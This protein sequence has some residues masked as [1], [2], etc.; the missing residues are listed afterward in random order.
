MKR[1]I[2]EV[3]ERVEAGTATEQELE[4]ARLWILQLKQGN[5]HHFT[6]EQLV[7]VSDQMWAAISKHQI[8]NPATQ[9]RTTTIKLW[10]RVA[11]IA[12]AVTALAFGVYFFKY[13]DSDKLNQNQDAVAYQNDIAPGRQGATLTLANGKTIKLTDATNGKLAEQSGVSITKTA[14]GKLIYEIKDKGVE[15]NN[16]NT[17]TTA[18]GETYD[19]RLP[20]GTLVSL[21]AASSLAY[22]ANFTGLKERRVELTG[23]GY[24]QV[25]KDKAHP[26]IVATAT[27]EV[28]VLG[29]HFNISAYPNETVKTTLAEGSVE[30]KSSQQSSLKQLLKPDQQA[31]LLANGSFKVSQVNTS[32]A[33]S[34]KDGYFYFD[35]TPASDVLHQLSRWYNV[36]ADFSNISDLKISGEYPKKLTLAKFADAVL[37]SNGIKI[38]LTDERRLKISG[39]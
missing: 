3:L 26:F 34:W 10:P 38:T 14:E 16:M 13:N 15:N 6:D 19:V 11:A 31:L 27:Q 7:D 36:D 29:T 33:I 35:N 23:E 9:T 22:P 17:L 2:K 21:N 30:L 20:D 18:K 32:A 8:D 39:K 37:F 24:F 1:N 25:A 12:A 5:A 4:M 28:E